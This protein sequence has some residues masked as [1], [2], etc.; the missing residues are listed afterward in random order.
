MQQYEYYKAKGDNFIP[1]FMSFDKDNQPY[2]FYN[3]P[4]YDVVEAYK[5]VPGTGRAFSDFC[6]GPF[7]NFD[8]AKDADYCLPIDD[9]FIISKKNPEIGTNVITF[10]DKPEVPEQIDYAH[11]DKPVRV[12]QPMIFN[13]LF[14]FTGLVPKRIYHGHR[15]RLT[16]RPREIT[17]GNTRIENPGDRIAF[18]LIQQMNFDTLSSHTANRF[19]YP[20]PIIRKEFDSQIMFKVGPSSYYMVIIQYAKPWGFVKKITYNPDTKNYTEERCGNDIRNYTDLA[21]TFRD[22]KNMRDQYVAKQYI[23]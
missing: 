5:I 16:C 11:T 6:S 14:G 2:S 12:S 13:Q 8:A 19:F 22:I 1:P 10:W 3:L 23:H 15:G 9:F 17:D 4:V 7:V 18:K 20:N 21:A